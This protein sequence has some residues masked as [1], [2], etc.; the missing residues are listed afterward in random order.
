VQ[1]GLVLVRKRADD[2]RDAHKYPMLTLKS[3]EP[4]GWINEGEV[5]VFYSKEKL[6]SKYLT[7]KGD[8]IIRLTTPYTAICINDKQEG[9][10]ISSNFAII[11]L[12]KQ[13]Y[14]P[15][16]V[17][18]FLNSE[19]I[20]KQFFKSSISTTIPLIKTTHLRDMEIPDKTLDI[21]KKIVELNQLQVKEK[22][23]LSRLMKEK[24]KLA[25]TSIN[26]IIMEK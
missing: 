2:N 12:K 13:L 10:V 24:E 14:I 1:T 17:A 19:I 21:Q 9:L 8:I 5:D 16:F 4:Q 6:A 18:L 23:L 7:N 25:K 3:F 11:R 15:E 22:I 20:E 26:K